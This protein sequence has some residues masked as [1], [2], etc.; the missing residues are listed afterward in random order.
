[1]SSTRGISRTNKATCLFIHQLLFFFFFFHS[2]NSHLIPFKGNANLDSQTITLPYHCFIY[3]ST[4]STPLL[5]RRL[6]YKALPYSYTHFPNSLDN[7]SARD[8]L[9]P[10]R[11]RS[12]LAN[13]LSKCAGIR[14]TWT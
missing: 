9:C 4:K 2:K 3:H 1:M 14:Y 7:R 10:H 8:Q 6:M 13:G 12:R 5:Y 11:R